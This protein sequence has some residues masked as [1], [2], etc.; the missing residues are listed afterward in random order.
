M[1][2]N[3][4]TSEGVARLPHRMVKYS[5]WDRLVN[6]V[7]LDKFDPLHYTLVVPSFDDI[8]QHPECKDTFDQLCEARSEE[9]RKTKAPLFVFYS[10]G[11]DS[12][13]V[14]ETIMKTWPKK[15]LE[16]VSVVLMS[17]SINEN[18]NAWPRIHKTFSGRIYNTYDVDKVTQLI[19]DTPDSLV[20]NGEIA[21]QLFG[22][23]V[24]YGVRDEFGF[25][26]IFKPYE[27]IIPKLYFKMFIT[28]SNPKHAM[29]PKDILPLFEDIKRTTEKCPFKIT[30]VFDYLWWFNYTNKTQHVYTRLLAYYPELNILYK[31]NRVKPFFY[32]LD[33]F[34]WSLDNHQ[35]NQKII[36]S[37]TSYKAAAKKY[38][39]DLTKDEDYARSKIKIGSLGNMLIRYDLHKNTRIGIDENF[40]Y[41]DYKEVKKYVR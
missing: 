1:L 3:L 19:L 25:E 7:E 28:N 30:T 22:A 36:K 18:P 13:V 32:T 20:I 9:L 38:L 41:L 16:R 17:A 24:I 15:D 6:T 40:D 35:G 2:L 23:D 29:N 34:R 11:I 31:E 27:E 12:S 33:F 8:L 4:I 26:T 14:L 21:D 10:G 37:I 39:Y 5:P